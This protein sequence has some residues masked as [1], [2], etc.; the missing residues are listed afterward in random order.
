VDRNSDNGFIFLLRELGGNG[1]DTLYGRI[2]LDLG[3]NGL[4]I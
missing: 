3:R 4:L 2:A 1:R